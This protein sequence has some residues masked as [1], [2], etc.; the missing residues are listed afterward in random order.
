MGFYLMTS[1][2]SDVV[3][4]KIKQYWPDEDADEVLKILSAYGTQEMERGKIRVYL[5]ILKLCE[6]DLTKLN[7]YVQMAKRDFRDVLAFAEYP[8]Q[9]KMGFIKMRALTP[10]DR[11]AMKQ[12]DAKQYSEWL[13]GD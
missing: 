3:L 9:M 8:E 12:R 1:K 7:E 2:H 13:N 6:G 4:Y 5:A 11:E 10:S